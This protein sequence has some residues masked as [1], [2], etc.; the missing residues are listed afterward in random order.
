MFI[1]PLLLILVILSGCI[2]EKGTKI[3]STSNPGPGDFLTLADA[4]IFLLRGTVY[5]NAEDIDWV[6]KMDYTL[7]KVAGEITKQT[8][9]PELFENE[10][11]SRLP[12]GCK[13]YETNQSFYIAVVNDREIP[14]LPMIEG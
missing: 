1:T 2:D 12:V 6:Q 4:D 7:G 11:A 5:S 13:I 8:S 9:E 10:T 3:Q 14:Y